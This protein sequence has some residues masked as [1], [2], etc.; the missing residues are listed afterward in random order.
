MVPAAR[1]VALLIG[2][3]AAAL[4]ACGGGRGEA[5]SAAAPD[6][7]APAAAG[8]E[9]TAPSAT[10]T[11]TPGHAEATGP[12]AAV[13]WLVGSWRGTSA[14]GATLEETWSAAEGTTM[15]GTSKLVGKDGKVTDEVLRIE[16]RDGGAIV[17][18]AQPGGAPP[19]EFTRDARTSGP[20]HAQFVN[21][22]H[23][24]PTRIRYERAGDELRVR[25]RGRPGQADETFVLKAR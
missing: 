7:A 18:V 8:T 22:Q 3:L 9:N 16:A 5:S 15:K 23:D 21:E 12:L 2:T 13:S 1:V 24:W 14:E 19:T 6:P 4:P 20:T 17:Y 11:A 10:T 25:L